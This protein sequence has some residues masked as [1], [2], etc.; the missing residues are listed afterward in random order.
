MEGRAA[1]LLTA[2]A[3]AGVLSCA[4]VGGLSPFGVAFVFSTLH[5]GAVGAAAALAT[6]AVSAAVQPGRAPAVLG[7]VAMGWALVGPAAGPRTRRLADWLAAASVAAARLTASGLGGG[8]P[9]LWWAETA[10]EAVLAWSLV[11]LWRAAAADWLGPGGGAPE[12][13]GGPPPGGDPLS[14]LERTAGLVA[15]AAALEAGLARLGGLG[16]VQPAAVALGYLVLASGAVLGPTP[17][18]AVS[19]LSGLMLGLAEP[20]WVLYGLVQAAAAVTCSAALGSRRVWPALCL[21]GVTGIGALA[22]PSSAWALWALGH[23]GAAAALFVLTPAGALARWERRLRELQGPSPRGAWPAAGAGRLTAAWLGDRVGRVIQRSQ[24]VV[25]ALRAAYETAAAGPAAVAPDPAGYVA[26]VQE[27]ACAGCPSFAHCWEES[28][29]ASL[30]DVM[31]FLQRAEQE[32]RAAPDAMPESLRRRCIRPVRLAQAVEDAARTMDALHAARR[33]AA[34]QTR[35]LLAQV[36]AARGVL[37]IL[38]AV[39]A[40]QVRALDASGAERLARHLAREGLACREVVLG[41]AGGRREAVV[42]LAAPCRGPQRCARSAERLLAEYEGVPW[43]AVSVRC[44]HGAPAADGEGCLVHLMRRPL[45]EVECA[46]ASRTRDGEICCGDSFA[47]LEP[48]P[49]LVAV[50]LSDGMGSGPEA[51]RESETAVRL[52]E[53]A[54]AAGAG[55]KEA[56]GLANGVLLARS[57]DERFATL[58][59]ALFDLAAGELELGKAGAYPTFVVGA[60]GVERVEGRALPAGIVAGVDVE[61]IRRPLEDGALVVMATDGAAELGEAGEA[62]LMEVLASLRGEAASGHGEGAEAILARVMERLD[63]MVGRR[64]RDD[65]TV[66]LVRTRQLDLAGVPAY[67]GAGARRPARVAASARR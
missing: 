60:S 4:R 59:V 65:V 58:D 34:L 24:Q 3:V 54:L 26:L 56:I 17:A 12:G 67:T 9:P 18:V 49:A 66:A 43:V 22:A 52:A 41:G 14:W 53:A 48:A 36:D 20:R 31:A 15:G 33:L 8:R 50:V 7:A 6:V 39:A 23:A 25:E 55:A 30:V 42:S 11:R 2:A 40:Q 46:F 62:C 64:W 51:A 13:R 61:P 27:R 45:W 19:V 37:E 35:R 47:R 28:A 16:P 63:G 38:A 44:R 5:L 1:R 32:G 29:Q 21:V 10:A 57:A